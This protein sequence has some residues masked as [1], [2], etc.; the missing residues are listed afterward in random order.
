M[1]TSYKIKIEPMT[2]MTFAPFGELWD[3]TD[4]PDDQRLISPTRYTYVGKTTVSVIWQP[5]GGLTFNELERHFGVTQSFVQLSGSPAVVCV[6]A[7]TK[8]ELP[9]D[10]PDPA[11]VRAFLIDPAKGYS[12]RRGTWH[13][14]NRHNLVPPGSTFLILNS[15][16]N[17]TQMVNYETSTVAIYQD[18]GSDLE[19]ERIVHEGKFGVVFEITL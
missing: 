19:P 7:P 4:R 15:D 18:L 5:Y 9:T 11:D 16:P 2:A 3:A 12:F 17:P 14:L 10:V 13:S 8:T 1:T 6:A